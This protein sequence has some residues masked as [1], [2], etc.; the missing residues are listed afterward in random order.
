[1]NSHDDLDPM[2]GILLGCLMG[3][4]VWICALWLA[5]C[6]WAGYKRGWQQQPE[7]TRQEQRI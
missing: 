6:F 7:P 5:W 2:R 1:M 4:A 3:L